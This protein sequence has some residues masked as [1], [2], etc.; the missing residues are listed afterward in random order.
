[1][2]E[3]SLQLGERKEWAV[4]WNLG[5][6]LCPKL[7]AA[8]TGNSERWQ[9]KAN[10]A[11]TQHPEMRTS[12]V[13][14]FRRPGLWLEGYELKQ[15]T[16]ERLHSGGALLLTVCTKDKRFSPHFIKLILWGGLR[17]KGFWLMKQS[18]DWRYNGKSKMFVTAGKPAHNALLQIFLHFTFCQTLLIKVIN[19]ILRDKKLSKPTCS[20]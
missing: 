11:T 20:C 14:G 6:W 7:L 15:E 18:W 2:K 9:L 5:W 1:M 3:H 13:N 17:L 10:T 4:D 12:R 16:V 19:Q 8:G